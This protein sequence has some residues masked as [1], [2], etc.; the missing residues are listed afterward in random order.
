MGNHDNQLLLRDLAQNLHDLYA[1]LR[2]QRTR[3]LVCQQN[4]GVVDKG[5]RNGDTLHLTAREL[6]WLFIQMRSKTNLFE[7][8]CRTAATLFFGDARQRECQFDVGKHGLV[9][10]EVV[11]LEYEADGVIAVGVPCRIIVF[12]CRNVVDD[13]ITA[14]VLIQSADDVE[15]GSLSAS[16]RT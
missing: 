15:Q 14:G 10:D 3:R 12:F 2:I 6:V 1:C 8:I 16:G 11:A 4:V 5:A 13:Q 7:C 9:G